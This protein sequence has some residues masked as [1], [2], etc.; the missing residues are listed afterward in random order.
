MK[1]PQAEDEDRQ[2]QEEEEPEAYVSVQQRRLAKVKALR[3]SR[4]KVTA[5]VWWM[6]AV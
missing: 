4:Q 6:V 5:L 3:E 2:E 1:R